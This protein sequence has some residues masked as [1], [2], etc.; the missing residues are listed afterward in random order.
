MTDDCKFFEW[1]DPDIPNYQKGV[2]LRLINE[3]DRLQ[4]QVDLKNEMQKLTANRFE[5][6]DKRMK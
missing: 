5:D 3:Q 2:M 1:V 6:N 4:E